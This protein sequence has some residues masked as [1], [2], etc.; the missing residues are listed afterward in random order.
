M[1]LPA[2]VELRG[3]FNDYVLFDREADERGYYPLY[4]GE[5]ALEEC[6]EQLGLGEGDAVLV[7]ESDNAFEVSATLRW[8][9]TPF[10]RQPFGWCA[11]ADWTTRID[12]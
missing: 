2:R 12:L 4:H 3:D 6:A 11:I 8:A 10:G 5:T 1:T 9:E 7:R